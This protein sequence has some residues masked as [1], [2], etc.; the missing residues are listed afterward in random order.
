MQ[1]RQNI[2][3]LEAILLTA[4]F[5]A[6]IGI[7]AAKQLIF[8]EPDTRLI[9]A[10][11]LNAFPKKPRK[12]VGSVR[13]F[14]RDFEGYYNDHFGFRSALLRLGGFVK[15][16]WLNI[17]PAA[18]VEIGKCGWL[19][20]KDDVNYH[21]T[22]ELTRDD[23]EH[24]RLTLE[25]RQEW[26]ASRGIRYIYVVA[27]D[28]RTIYPDFL[29]DALNGGDQKTAGMQLVEYL[30]VHSKLR[31][32]S[33]REP[34]LEA[35][36]KSGDRLYYPTDT[37]WNTVGANWGYRGI[38]LRLQQWFPELKPEERSD[39]R[40][41]EE[42]H[43]GDLSRMIGLAE[44]SA[45]N[46][47]ALLPPDTPQTSKTQFKL[48]DVEQT[49]GTLPFKIKN[50]S[51]SSK[52]RIVVLRDSFCTAL[53]PYFARQFSETTF[54]YSTEMSQKF[55]TDLGDLVEREKPDV[56]IEERVERVLTGGPPNESLVFGGKKQ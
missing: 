20:L 30:S 31:I 10:R 42:I 43:M 56:F 46:E 14:A 47:V 26:L 51:A 24:W 36:A 21:G 53:V 29:P 4:L 38:I 34:L 13:Q 32:V 1:A 16:Q 2:A 28:K 23:L 7:P 12:S 41:T 52:L 39:F 3:R 40:I 9:E 45:V 25:H 55:E 6:G 27:P 35:R 22:H 5:C 50:A 15:Y 19:F 18:N 8:G 11:K 54:I 37:H 49:A 17:S 33:L 48:P 44:S